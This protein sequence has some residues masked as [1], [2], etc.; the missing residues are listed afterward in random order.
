MDRKKNYRDNRGYNK[1]KVFGITII[2]LL[3]ALMPMVSSEPLSPNQP[4]YGNISSINPNPAEG[5]IYI[6]WYFGDGDT[7]TSEGTGWP[8]N[9]GTNHAYTAPGTYTVQ[10]HIVDMGGKFDDAY[11]SVTV[12][13]DPPNTPSTPSGPTSLE[14]SQSGTY[15]TSATDPEGNQV[16][17]RFDWDADGAHDYSSWTSLGASGHT[18]SMDHSWSSAGT[19]TVKAQARDE[20]NEESSWSN[21][22]SVIVNPPNQPPNQPNNPDPSNGE[23]DVDID[24]DISWSCTDPDGD[25]LTFNVHFG[26]STNPQLVATNIPVFN[27]DPGTLDFDETYYWK[28]IAYDEIGASNVG[29]LWNF[30]TEENNPPNTPSNPYPTDGQNNLDLDITLDWDCSDPDGDSLT[31]DVYFGTSSNPN[32]IASDIQNSNYE[33]ETLDYET[34]YYWKIVARDEYDLETSGPIWSFT[35]KS[36]PQYIPN[37]K[38]EGSLTWSSVKPGSVNTGSFIVKNV[39]DSTS[40]LDWEITEYPEWGTFVFTPNSGDDLTPEDGEI[41]VEVTV[42]APDEINEQFSGEIKIENTENPS[43]YEIIQ[44]SISTPRSRTVLQFF[45]NILEKLLFK[46]IWMLIFS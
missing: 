41:T 8:Y 42:T 17:Y 36:A 39:G 5:T 24:H 27:Y 9:F 44:I 16:Q 23:T 45:Q 31:Y 19:Y 43:D 35:T 1:L 10:L 6:T 32:L 28:I 25:S 37:L 13:N 15:S 46:T 38:C 14:V 4:P 2:F 11:G 34:T 40:E 22:L 7:A 26:T 29:P 18:G 33:I 3:I 21:G 12:T 20:F 30:V